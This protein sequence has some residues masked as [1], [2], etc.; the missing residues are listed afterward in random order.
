MQIKNYCA[1]ICIYDSSE[2]CLSTLVGIDKEYGMEN[3]DLRKFEINEEEEKERKKKAAIIIARRRKRRGRKLFLL[4]LILVMTGIMLTTTTYAWFTSNKTVSVS[5][6]QVNVASKNGIQISADGTNWKSIIQLSD[7]TGAQATYP[8]A[9]N[10]IPDTANT[11]EPVSTGFNVD[12]NG[13][14][15]MFYGTIESSEFTGSCSSGDAY[16]T[17]STCTAAGGIWTP[18]TEGQYILTA[19]KE[20]DTHGTTGKYVAFDLFFRVDALTQVYL[21]AEGSGVTATGADT[22]IKNASRIAFVELGNTASGSS[23][24]TIQ[25]LN[26]GVAS[27]VYSWE[28]NYDIH[29]ASGVSNAKDVYDITTTE[30][31]GELIHYSGVIAEV[32]KATNV[33][34]G[35]A[36]QTDY[37]TLFKDVTPTYSTVY[38]WTGTQAIFSLKAGITKMRIYMWVE[39]Q[40]VDCENTASGGNIIYSLQI[41]TESGA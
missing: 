38:G 12:S 26:A 23:L 9:V 7:L 34:L 29:T 32:P 28:P 27:N 3:N 14:M 16:T 36:T 10:Q 22:G 8:A 5:D 24:T 25:G 37:S 4:L 35:K 1:I 33:L 41:T 19:T 2:G 6:V 18:S 20:T 17:E 21:A 13:R 31:G 15:E 30:A 40:D 11:I 39:G